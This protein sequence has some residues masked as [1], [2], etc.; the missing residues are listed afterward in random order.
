MGVG[1]KNVA[2]CILQFHYCWN[3]AISGT[4]CRA[5]LCQQTLKLNGYVVP[6][7]IVLAACQLAVSFSRNLSWREMKCH[8][9]NPNR[10]LC[11]QRGSEVLIFMGEWTE[12]DQ[13]VARQLG[14]SSKRM[15]TR[16]E[17]AL[18]HE[19]SKEKTF[20]TLRKNV[21][22]F[23]DIGMWDI[24]IILYPSTWFSFVISPYSEDLVT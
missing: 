15:V 11:F 3:T 20:A 23:W 17:C 8:L 5:G 18:D 12:R 1:V 24:F 2:L 13:F 4:E 19:S 22:Y 6:G 21:C 7:N 16:W 9:V 14:Y 10:M